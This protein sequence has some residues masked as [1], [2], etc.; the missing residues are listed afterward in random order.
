M[1]PSIYSFET[2]VSGISAS[3]IA[4]FLVFA[5]NFLFK[6]WENY[7]RN[8]KFKNIFGNLIDE[9]LNL[10]V[11][12]L[13]FRSDV[14]QFL[15][16][17]QTGNMSY[18]LINS[19]GNF[20]KLSKLIAFADTVALK[21]ILDLSSKTLGNKSVIVTDSELEK[22]LDISLV[23]FGGSSFYCTYVLDQ[24]DN[25]YYKFDPHSIVSIKDPS[26][27]F[28]LDQTYDYGF[29]IKYKH[30]NFQ[31]KTWI[32]IAGI[33]ESGTRGASYFLYKNW[34]ILA[35][36]FKNNCFGIVVKVNHGIDHSAIEVNRIIGA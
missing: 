33:G 28:I 4:S 22:K 6:L 13:R 32:I 11:P 19:S 31:N 14:E 35:S 10:V 23:S 12:S 21:Y 5:I 17:N 3:L 8:N 25:Q 24:S 34:K 1:E 2:W 18:P 7:L 16:N 36:D 27:K 30:P 9:E 29:I 15:A 26:T 20:I